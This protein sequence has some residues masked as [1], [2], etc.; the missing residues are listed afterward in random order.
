[1]HGNYHSC[2]CLQKKNRQEIAQ[3]T[4]S[5]GVAGYCCGETAREFIDRADNAL[6]VS[7]NRG[8]NRV[9]VAPAGL[10]QPVERGG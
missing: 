7:K 2:G 8:R 4:V 6:Y 1:M 3:I 9:T 5:F 10:H